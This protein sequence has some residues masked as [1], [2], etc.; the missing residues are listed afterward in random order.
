MRFQLSDT[1]VY[2]WT[3]G[4]YPHQSDKAGSEVHELK[5]SV[6][7]DHE[8]YD[9][10]ELGTDKSSRSYMISNCTHLLR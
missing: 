1:S 3:L 8:N 7:A 10:Q 6:C 5:K 9:S 2:K 4:S